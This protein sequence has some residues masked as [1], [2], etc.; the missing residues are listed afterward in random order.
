MLSLLLSSSYPR[1][2]TF[3]RTD[4]L[5]LRTVKIS[6]MCIKRK[7][8]LDCV[9]KDM[10][11]WESSGQWLVWSYSPMKEELNVSGFPDFLP[12]QFHLECYDCRANSN[13]QNYINSVQ[14]N[15]Q[16]RNQLPQLKALNALTKAAVPSELK[17]ITQPLPSFGFGGPKTSSFGLPSFPM[18]CSSATSFSFTIISSLASAS[19]SG[20]S[21]VF[22]ST[23]AG[24][25]PPVFGATSLPRNS[26][27][28][29]P[30]STAV[31]TAFGTFNAAV[32][33]SASH[34][35]S[36]LFG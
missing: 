31:H 29:N 20:N 6:L 4:F 30:S 22:E 25:N 11:I 34:S 35:S 12:Q 2:R 21:D 24:C 28:V 16:W 7:R 23:S 18:N 14:Q 3:C 17:T 10:E 26:S 8:L 27:A 36:I 1:S 15:G 13:I 5:H 33:T 19:S 9:A 32:A